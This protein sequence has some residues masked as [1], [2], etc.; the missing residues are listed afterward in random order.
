M[1]GFEYNEGTTAAFSAAKN[2]TLSPI[3]VECKT[4]SKTPIAGGYRMMT[5]SA[6]N[7]SV[8]SS[9]PATNAAGANGWKLEVKNMFFSTTIGNAAVK[10]W[11]HCADVK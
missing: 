3:F 9:A 4:P 11:V 2:V 10:V 7:L 5:S 1:S 6:E 8:I